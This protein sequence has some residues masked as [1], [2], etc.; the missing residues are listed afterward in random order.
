M[1]PVLSLP[2]RVP[3]TDSPED[4]DDDDRFSDQLVEAFLDA[5][6]RPGDLVLDP[7][8]GFGTTLV[9][10]E[11]MGRRTLGLEILPERVEHIRARVSDPATVIEADARRLATLDLPPVDFTLTSPPYMTRTDHPENPLTGYQT[12]DGDYGRYLDE[13]TAVYGAIGRLLTPGA[14]AVINVSNLRT[15]GTVSPLAWDVGAAVSRVLRFEQ[16]IILDWD[17]PEDWYTND[18]CLVFSS[19]DDES[20]G[21]AGQA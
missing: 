1:K 14:K 6:T 21:S 13:L 12:L 4:G 9:V 19:F 10:A 7:F 16:E 3:R 15:D 2:A 11:R 17:D 8:A 18:Y 5:Y 20:T